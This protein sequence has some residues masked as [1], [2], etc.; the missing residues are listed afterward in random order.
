MAR[1]SRST[2]AT[3][4]GYGSVLIVMKK[5]VLISTLLLSLSA[6]GAGGFRNLLP[7]ALYFDRGMVIDVSRETILLG[8]IREN[9]FSCSNEYL[10][11]EGTEL[12][13]WHPKQ[14][15]SQKTWKEKSPGGF[16]FKL[17]ELGGAE[18]ENTQSTF[19]LYSDE[20][21][22]FAWHL[23]YGGFAD[24]YPVALLGLYF[25]SSF[26][27]TEVVER[28]LSGEDM[29]EYYYQLRNVDPIWV[30]D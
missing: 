2:I 18:A 30:C 24:H 6:C 23:G 26:M 3:N 10:C 17:E 28:L 29:S 19:L 20:R 13:F 7:S 4:S 27:E 11:L 25:D 14:C 1:S 5:R 12:L 15:P 9:V 21:H 16:E 22:N 8:G